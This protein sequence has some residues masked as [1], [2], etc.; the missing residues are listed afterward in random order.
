MRFN[1]KKCYIMSINNKSTNFYELDNHILQ[2]V[3][4][5]PYLGVTF[6]EDLTFRNHIT[7]ITN[8]ASSTLGFLRRNLKHCPTTC[9]RTAYLSL[10]RSTLEYSCSVWDPPYQRDID[11][12]ERIQRRAARFITG[13]YTSQEQGCVTSMLKTLDLEPLQDRRKKA[14][15]TF[16]FKVAEGLVPAMPPLAY[17]TPIRGK[18]LIRPK[19][20]TDCVSSNII[21]KQAVNHHK[22]YQTIQCKS[23]TYKNSFFPKTV[24]DWNNLD[25]KVVCAET[26]QSFRGALTQCA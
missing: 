16:F 21:T 7:K 6:T 2:Q 14:R 8:K 26:V 11:N 15:L 17:L 24:I 18:R 10:V 25:T 1:A 19:Q 3:E 20:F 5:N 22:C 13:D 4:E 9:R 23:D 12:L